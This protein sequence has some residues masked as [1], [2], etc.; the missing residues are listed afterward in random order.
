MRVVNELALTA[1]FFSELS[2]FI[3]LTALPFSEFHHKICISAITTNLK[4][5]VVHAGLILKKHAGGRP[6]RA[7]H[8][9]RAGAY[10]T[11]KLR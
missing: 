5:N 1:Q 7:R 4:E 9:G 2:L 8:E 11:L 3:A 10:K 6:Q